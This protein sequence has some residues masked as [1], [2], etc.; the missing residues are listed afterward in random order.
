MVLGLALF[1]WDKKLGS[2]L[3]IKYPN[4]F[5]LSDA[6]I[7]KIYMTHAYQ[8]KNQTEELIEINLEKQIILSYCDISNVAKFGYEILVLIVH[9]KEKIHVQSLKSKLLEFAREMLKIPKIKRKIYFVEN[10]GLFFK[11]TATTKK[12]L[13]V[14]RA[15][16]GKS[17]IKEVI[18]EG[19]LPQEIISNPLEPTRGLT[20]SVY[21]WLDID[22]GIFDSAGQELSYLLEDKN[23]QILAF[24]NTD[25]ILYIFDYLM[26]IE[27][28]EAIFVDIKKISEIIEQESYKAKMMLFL[29]KIDLIDDKSREKIIDDIKSQVEDLLNLQ[30][31]FTSLYPNLIYNTYNAFYEI[32]STDS[33]ETTYIKEILDEKIIGYSKSLCFI[34]NQNSSI[35]AQSMSNDF[36]FKIINQIHKL[37]VQLDQSFEDMCINDNID[38]LF[39]SSLKEF[40]VILKYLNLLKFNI[41]NLILISETINVNNLIF[42]SGEMNRE[43][44]KYFYKD[45]QL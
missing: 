19:K 31:Y 34:T 5:D 6:L 12:I 40:N 44:N 15:A 27:N 7:N 11:E 38:Y 39:L 33:I 1:S 14:G 28:K 16:T 32:L 29:H 18:F 22:L 20:P 24:E 17:S 30:I 3:E 41:K 8:Q 37:I 25:I 35:I 9:E 21:S 4:D 2:V 13:L 23:E 26:W 43:L 45:Y 36:N 10:L 42:L